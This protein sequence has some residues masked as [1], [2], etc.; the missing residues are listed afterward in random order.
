MRG[1]SA[2][3]YLI[4]VGIESIRK[5]SFD[6]APFLSSLAIDYYISNSAVCWLS[7]RD[8]G[9]AIFAWN[10]LVFPQ[11][12]GPD[13]GTM[14]WELNMSVCHTKENMHIWL[15]SRLFKNAWLY[16]AKCGS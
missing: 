13:W 5:P 4:L 2:P 6:P 7:E 14:P 16:S 10:L 3:C 8:A 15:R 1:K 11:S 9:Q 12:P